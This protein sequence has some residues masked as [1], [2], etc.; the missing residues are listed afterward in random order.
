MAWDENEPQDG[1]PLSQGAGAIRT[2]KA[3][4]SGNISPSMYWSGTSY[5]EMRLGT[6]RAHYGA[7]SLVSTGPALDTYGNA[8]LYMAS[9]TSRVYSIHT[10][11]DSLA[12][13]SGRAIEYPASLVTTARW[14]LSRGTGTQGS[15]M[16]YGVTYNGIPF[17]QASYITAA[18]TPSFPIAIRLGTI[19]AHQFT[20]STYSLTDLGGWVQHGADIAWLSL[21]SVSF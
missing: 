3:D 9:D 17:V 8:S 5:G 13:L 19:E 15:T 18:K 20:P 2:L 21:G 6:F 7:V 4:V 11:I 14:V 12:V 10:S 16:P 1:A